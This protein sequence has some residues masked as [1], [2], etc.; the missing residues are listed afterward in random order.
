MGSMACSVRRSLVLGAVLSLGCASE[1]AAL[2]DTDTDAGSTGSTTGATVT[3]TSAGSSS[4]TSAGTTTT[5]GSTSESSSSGADESTTGE[6]VSGPCEDLDAFVETLGG[7]DPGAMAEMVDAFIADLQ[8]ETH[9]LPLRCENRVVFVSTQSRFVAGDFNDWDPAALPMEQP[10]A[11]APLWLA[12]ADVP[13]PGGLYKFVE[14]DVSAAAP[15][16][17]RYGWDEFGEYSQVDGD[18]ARSHHE[19][20]PGFAEA[21]EPLEPRTVRVF[22]PAAANGGDDVPVLYMHDGQNLFSPDAFFGGW[23][24]SVTA[25]AL[26]GEGSMRPVLIVGIDNTPARLEEY[27]HVPDDIGDGPI[28]GL[29][30]DYADFVV[31][32]VVPF[33]ESRYPVLTGPENTAV[34]G[35]SMGGLVSLHL[36]HRHPE[37]FGFVGSMSGTLAWGTFGLDNE[38][39]IERY[40]AGAPQGA[41]VYI[42]SGGDGP[43][44][45][46]GSDN[47]CEAV[48]LADVLRD[49]GWMDEGDLFYRWGPGAPHNEASWADRL[50]GALVDWFP[51]G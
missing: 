29:A 47:Y 2:Q 32:G 26:V 42:D 4:V 23:Q 11:D 49:Q 41:S 44:P 17:R 12:E 1:P 7:A 45:G 18:P 22:V 33:V 31:E 48:E 21:V 9:G 50:P 25:D 14:G 40:A 37:V 20:W 39:M 15:L 8:Y 5:D 16:A 36:A 38:T 24:A 51:G 28:G 34:L 6:P 19:R 10:V 3:P 35:S 13:T 43:C 27:S 30:D 46:G